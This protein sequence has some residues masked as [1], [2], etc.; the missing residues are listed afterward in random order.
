LSVADQAGVL[1]SVTSILADFGISIDAMLQ[2]P[3][4]I[5]QDHTELVILTHTAKESV[6]NQAL[7]KIQKLPTV[8]VPVVRIR[9]EDLV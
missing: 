2:Q 4:V 3:A 6:M 8:L 1:A 9:K 7:Q 5:G